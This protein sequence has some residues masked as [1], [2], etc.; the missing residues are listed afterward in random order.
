MKANETLTE[1]VQFL[2]NQTTNFSEIK[3]NTILPALLYVENAA[4]ASFYISLLCKTT[5][6]YR[7]SSCST[8]ISLQLICRIHTD[9][10]VDVG[11]NNGGNSAQT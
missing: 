5:F 9:P 7:L 8:S 3:F 6:S 11:I 4:S 1:T 10:K 2:N